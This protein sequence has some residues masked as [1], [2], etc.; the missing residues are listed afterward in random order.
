MIDYKILEDQGIIIVEPSGSLE[1]EDFVNLTRDA[2]A[3]LE[4]HGRLNGL[5]IHANTFPGWE[6]F[7]AFTYHFSFIR[8]HHEKVN[9]IAIVTDSAFLKIAPSIANHFVAAEVK[10]FD[11]DDLEEA[12]KWAAEPARA[13]T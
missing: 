2:D 9:R 10:H 1:K 5:V 4:K 3:Y 12:Q 13:T 8:G 7:G 6:D 11:Y